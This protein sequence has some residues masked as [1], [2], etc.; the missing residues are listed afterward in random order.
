MFARFE[1]AR[2]LRMTLRAVCRS[3]SDRGRALRLHRFTRTDVEALR[4]RSS[5]FSGERSIQAAS[6]SSRAVH[7]RVFLDNETNA[8]Q[9]DFLALSELYEGDTKRRRFVDEL[10]A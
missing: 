5:I 6:D 4:R 7:Y 2:T 8:A 1:R 3:R 9:A 10:S